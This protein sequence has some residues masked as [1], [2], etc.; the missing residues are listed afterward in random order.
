VW[1]S[2]EPAPSDATYTTALSHFGASIQSDVQQEPA[3][4]PD[5]TTGSSM[6]GRRVGEHEQPK[7]VNVPAIE[8][9]DHRVVSRPIQ[10]RRRSDQVTR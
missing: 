5:H 10:R 9:A 2:E 4:A 1:E 6:P 3:S 7:G 8:E